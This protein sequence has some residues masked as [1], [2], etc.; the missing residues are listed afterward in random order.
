MWRDELIEKLKELKEHDDP[1]SAH[2]LADEYLLS[3][4]GDKEVSEL[5][6]NL[7]RWYS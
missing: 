5:F 4:I 7:E 2:E 3:Y 1:A 6:Y